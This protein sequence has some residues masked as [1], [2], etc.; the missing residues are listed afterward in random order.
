MDEKNNG[1]STEASRRADLLCAAARLMRKKGYAATTIREIAKA[2]GMGSGSPFCH[3]RSKEE[4]LA[5][6][7][8]RGMQRALEG[9]ETLRARRMQARRRLHALLR[10]HVELLHGREGDFS[11]V[12]LREWRALAPE[13]RRRLSDMMDRYEAIW[14][15]C[16]QKLEAAEHLSANAALAARLMLGS[17]NWSLHWY[18]RDGQ[19]APAQ[20]ADGAAALFLVALPAA[21]PAL[22]R[23]PRR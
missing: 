18:R 9:A 16:L 11:A 3:F 10:L 1:R 20:L 6:I 15:E 23:L 12:M 22:A 2:V 8:L 5:A 4:I 14:R 21:R 13:N 17:L 7:A 19:L